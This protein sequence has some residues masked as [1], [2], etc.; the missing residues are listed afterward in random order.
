MPASFAAM[1]CVLAVVRQILREGR[2]W[3]D[4]NVGRAALLLSCLC[5]A[6]FVVMRLARKDMR[7]Y[8]LLVVAAA[9]VI[10]S[11]VTTRALEV[12]QVHEKRL[13]H[14]PVSRMTL[15]VESDPT[16]GERGYRCR[17]RV[18]LDGSSLGSV[19]LVCPTRP[20]R[21]A[22]LRCVGTY[23]P[24]DDDEW[25]VSARMQGIVG[26]VRASRVLESWSQEGPLSIVLRARQATLEALCPQESDERALLA[27]C[28]CGW[29]GALR[30][31][32]LDELFATTGTAH[33]VAVSGSHLSIVT[34]LVGALLGRMRLRRTR[35]TVLLLMA[36]GIY[37]LFCG[38]PVSAVRAW[39]MA[40]MASVAGTA[41]R[42]SYGL[43]AVSITALVMALA[44]P[45]VCGQ[46]GFVLS[47]CSVSALCLFGPYATVVCASFADGI[48]V[49]RRV[50]KALRRRLHG[51]RDAIVE[52]FSASLV[53]S[54]ATMPLVAQSFGRVSLVGPVAS[55][56]LC[57]PFPALMFLGV[58]SIPLVRVPIVGRC[59]LAAC[60]TV[61]H[62]VLAAMR[63]VAGVPYASLP[64][65]GWGERVTI[66]VCLL[67]LALFVFWPRV[68]TRRAGACL[69][70]LAVLFVVVTLR[71]E[72]GS[73]ARICV[74]NVG[75]GDAILVQDGSSTLLVDAGADDATSN[76]LARNGVLHLDAVVITHMHD[77]H[78]GGMQGLVG[79]VD[80]DAVYVGAGVKGHLPAELMQTIN[81]L[82]DIPVEEMAYGDTLH[83]GAFSLR[84]VWPT[85]KTD[86]TTNAD[87]IQLYID[88]QGGDGSLCGLLTGDAEQEQLAELI[89]HNDVGDIDF[90]KVG[91]H[92]SS[93]SILP[94]QARQLDPEVS[95][96]SA[97]EHNRYGHPTRACVEAL[98]DVGSLFLCTKD[99]GDV[100][101]TPGITGPTVRTQ[102]SSLLPFEE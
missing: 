95:V 45:P 71:Q 28:V 68:T 93:V 50:P 39:V 29:R 35:A 43:S 78:Y 8:G 64:T 18:M 92:G 4:G 10:A 87:S 21:G 88:Y 19:W 26:S 44:D 54:C 47:V 2:G 14:T 72:M 76:A 99:V 61:A 81:A 55:I 34:M 6:A 63:L 17:A 101:V 36:S 94:E 5:V 12:A 40:S 56:V 62:V 96:A 48:R 77:D 65:Q 83:V 57:V 49:P 22:V 27:G 80:C 30:D 41:G 89:N 73:H 84:M 1:V 52:S 46:L 67:A 9:L 24:N 11:L 82:G 100:E 7:P 13:S 20:D 66:L 69:G 75:Q 90:L 23:H 58:L 38:M 79:L 37:V 98:E 31:R 97:G 16:E 25:G 15:E 53:A 102:S 60:D 70:A 51:A 59:A 33:L 86:G 74:L 42:R 32:G 85:R 3:M 91:H